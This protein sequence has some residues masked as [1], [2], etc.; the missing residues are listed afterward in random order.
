MC[1]CFKMKESTSATK[2]PTDGPFDVRYPNI[3]SEPIDQQQTTALI[4]SSIDDE[5]KNVAN[6]I[7]STL[8][9]SSSSNMDVDSKDTDSLI[10]DKDKNLA[11]VDSTL[12][13]DLNQ[14]EDNHNSS[15]STF[16]D[17]NLDNDPNLNNN[18]DDD[19][20]FNEEEYTR[21]DELD[22]KRLRHLGLF[23]AYLE[24]YNQLPDLFKSATQFQVGLTFNT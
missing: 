22:L 19:E 17:E 1:V 10:A 9:S 12:R 13:D 8:A 2:L 24:F 6:N 14:D 4:T 7:T 20:L 11:D 21:F 23:K 18:E 16:V 15:T 5:I 3:K